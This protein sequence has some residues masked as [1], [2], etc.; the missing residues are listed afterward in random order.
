[1]RPDLTPS[2]AKA[3]SSSYAE[4]TRLAYEAGGDV[5]PRRRILALLAKS[6]E[7]VWTATEGVDLWEATYSESRRGL[8]SSLGQLADSKYGN[9]LARRGTK[10][11]YVFAFSDP[12][13]RPYLRITLAEEQ[14]DATT[15]A[16]W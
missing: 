8:H 10:R 11:R 13:L 16:G 15:Y 4:R 9:I 14:Q 5:Q 6:P 1:M 12:H 3:V 7:R 2:H